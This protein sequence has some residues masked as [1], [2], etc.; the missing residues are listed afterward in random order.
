MYKTDGWDWSALV[1]THHL[2][3]NCQI[4]NWQSLFFI[5]NKTWKFH[6]KALKYAPAILSLFHLSF[7]TH[8]GQS[9][10]RDTIPV[11]KNINP[12]TWLAKGV[13]SYTRDKPNNKMKGY[14]TLQ[15]ISLGL[16]AVFLEPLQ[17]AS[18]FTCP[19]DLNLHCQLFDSWFISCFYPVIHIPL[20][21]RLPILPL[22]W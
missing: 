7:I 2:Q 9:Q 20:L 3:S 14:R 21:Y 1:V 6:Q 12:N 10:S 13:V 18:R 19:K 8:S 15:I 16:N 11:S 17:V 5:Y 22:F 4:R